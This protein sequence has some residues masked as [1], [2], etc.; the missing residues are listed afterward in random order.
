MDLQDNILLYDQYDEEDDEFDF[1][2]EAEEEKPEHHT[3]SF[4]KN[5]VEDMFRNLTENPAGMEK[6]DFRMTVNNLYDVVDDEFEGTF[7]QP[8]SI[9]RNT[10]FY[11]FKEN[12]KPMV[13]VYPKNNFDFWLK[14]KGSLYR[15]VAKT[16]EIKGEE[17]YGYAIPL[18]VLWEYFSC[19]ADVEHNE[20]LT[21]SYQA[22]NNLTQFILRAIRKLYFIP[23]VEMSDKLFSVK[24]ELFSF[25][26]ELTAS[27]KKLSEFDFDSFSDIKNTKDYL[28]DKYLNY[29]M[30]KYIGLK[31]SRFRDLKAAVYF[32]KPLQ[33]KR[34]FRSTDVAMAISDWLDEI[35]IGKYDIV[36]VLHIA[37]IT[38]EDFV[39]TV[40]IKHKTEG[41]E[42]EILPVEVLYSDKKTIFDKPADFVTSIIEKQLNYALKYYPELETLFEEENDFKLK[43]NVN[44]VYKVMANTAYYL[45]KAGIELV[46]PEDFGNIVV[47]R[48][49][50]NARVKAGRE[51]DLEEL[52]N[53]GANN[54]NLHSIFDFDYKI[55]IGDDKISVEEF[56]A[57]TKNS[58]G[59]VAYKNMYIL[60]EQDEAKALIDKVKNP[61]IETLT[62]AELLHAAL[63]G[64]VKDYEFDYDAAFAN[65]LKDLTKIQEVT[66]PEALNGTLRSYQE[67]G[68]RWLYTNT[69]KGFGT[70]IADDMGLGK[71]IQVISL[72]LKL[73]EENRIKG[74]TLVVCPTTLLGNWVK[75]LNG[76][77]PSLSVSVY[78][79]PER[80]LDDK[81][82]VI[83]TT[84]AVL[85][86][87]IDTIKKKNWGM[88]IVDEAQNIKNPDTSQT[89][90]VKSLK[91]EYKVAMTGTP[92]E[93]RLTELWS[94]FDFI[95][96]G[97]L[98]TIREFQKR[99]A[100]PIEKFK[101]TNRAEKLKLSISPFVLRRLKT[102]KSV[103]SD[104]PEKVVLD[105]YCYLSKMQA[106]LYEST[107]N[108]IMGKISEAQGINRR[109]MIFKLI[110]A[111]KQI[112]NHPYQYKKAGEMTK[113]VS[114]KCDKFI[115]VL[116]GILENKEK[117][118][119]FTQYKEMGKI[120][121]P[122]VQNE[123]STT[124][125]FFH[126]SLNTSQREAMLK[127]FKEDDE[128]KIMILSLKAG[129]TGL[130]LTNATNVIHY[131]LWWNPAVEDQATDRTYRIG[132]TNNVMVHRLITLG[133][134]EEKIDEM[135]KKKKELVNMAVFEGEKTI[136]DLTDEEIYNI[137]TL[138]A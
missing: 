15:F 23:K 85:R 50:I 4:K 5:N 7:P 112:C 73:K 41:Q 124:P 100:V 108:D 49:S 64:N 33:Q 88:L 44:E 46:L 13:F 126:G 26:D 114:G 48:A 93:N 95:N 24:Y 116:D 125:L 8:V 90:A 20:D 98:G 138:T 111:L 128:S 106:A 3:Y 56:E 105:E 59:L 113:D 137:F 86:I 94:I 60:I 38:D 61:T 104:L 27:L 54:M 117:T 32:M 80:Q 28:I 2:E 120:L 16:K 127:Q 89:V 136:T 9:L 121:V 131:D 25:T 77:A 42:P 91:A 58:K 55:A 57:L 82:D 40:Q 75:E 134:F 83:I 34:Y 132:Q 22:V 69:V 65:I 87:D 103:I 35:Y 74:Q 52:L 109:G 30:F 123:L 6:K 129:G 118:V 11:F 130:N 45:N 39:L 110:T 17:Q 97:Y 19:F 51:S 107:L 135:I 101:Q 96:K 12:G 115:S 47:P 14:S 66:P 53:F 68:L 67:K 133:T 21:V 1:D 36:P 18:E 10:D 31:I 43:L 72:I 81:A 84:F 70:C 119:V 122:I 62:R 78:H 99:Y 37:K 71:T 76:F 63:S 79:G 29:I 102:D 92:V